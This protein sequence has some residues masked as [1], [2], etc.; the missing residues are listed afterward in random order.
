MAKAVK[1]SRARALSSEQR[2]SAQRLFFIFA[3]FN[4]VSFQFLSGNIIT[5]YALR[6]QASAAL[7]GLL[8]SFIPLAQ[9]LPLLGRILVGRFG[10]VRTMSM[11]SWTAS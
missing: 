1:K 2:A 8:F 11:C 4:V 6:L 7:V 3:T 5:L 9:L 10:T